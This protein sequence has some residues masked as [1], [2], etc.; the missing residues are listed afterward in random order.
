MNISIKGP[1]FWEIRHLKKVWVWKN[2]TANQW[3]VWSL[4]FHSYCMLCSNT[5]FGLWT[6]KAGDRT[7]NMVE[8]IFLG[9]Y[10]P[11]NLEIKFCLLLWFWEISDT[12]LIMLLSW[13]NTVTVTNLLSARHSVWCTVEYCIKVM[14]SKYLFHNLLL[15]YVTLE[16]YVK[17]SI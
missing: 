4:Y 1:N 14:T 11:W 9:Y 15:C 10:I 7:L 13:N 5:T 8:A 2:W 16:N 12:I 17:N 3:K 6:M